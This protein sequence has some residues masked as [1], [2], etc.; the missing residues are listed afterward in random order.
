MIWLYAKGNRSYKIADIPPAWIK[1]KITD[2]L[3]FWLISLQVLRFHLSTSANSIKKAEQTT[4]RSE[5]YY[6]Q[7]ALQQQQQQQKIKEQC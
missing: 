3:F 5:N 7:L 4:E 1:K 2:N 6:M